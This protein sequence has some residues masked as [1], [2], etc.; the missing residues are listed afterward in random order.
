MTRNSNRRAAF[1]LVEMLVAAT[2]IIFMMYVLASAFEK[3]LESFRVLKAQGDMNEKLRAAASALRL[4]LATPHFDGFTSPNVQGPFLSNQRLNDQTWQPPAKGYFR[5]SLP[6]INPGRQNAAQQPNVVAPAAG[7]IEGTDP[8]NTN[9][10]Y[11]RLAYQPGTSPLICTCKDLYLQFTVNL[12][13]GHPMVRD[14]RGR[15]DQFN[16]TDTFDASGDQSH[17]GLGTSGDGVLNPYS[18]PEYNR[19]DRSLHP[20]YVTNS[21]GTPQPAGTPYSTLY[22]SQ[23]AEVCY[24]L[25]P[26]TTRTTDAPLPL[27]DLY[28]RQKMLVEPAPPNTYPVKVPLDSN[29]K[30]I[31]TYGDLSYWSAQVPSGNN[32]ATVNVFNGAAHVTMPQRRWGMTT[33]QGNVFYPFGQPATNL[34]PQSIQPFRRAMDEYATPADPS[35][36]SDPRSGGDL[37]LTDVVNFEI[38]ALWEPVRVGAPNTDRFR[39]PVYDQ[40][41]NFVPPAYDQNGNW[42]G[43][44]LPDYFEPSPNKNPDYPFDWLPQGI[45]PGINAENS[46]PP[47]VPPP[48]VFDTWS[49]NTDTPV[50]GGQVYNYGPQYPT[51]TT[52]AGFPVGNQMMQQELGMWNVGHF[53]PITGLTPQ[54]GPQQNPYSPTQYTI[55]LRV[56]VR[57]LQIKLRIWD[58]KS[59]QTRQITIIQDV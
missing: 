40:N 19:G 3:G 53:T 11:Y 32:T 52:Q 30:S 9:S 44:T 35:G 12:T 41:G 37:L 15:R 13:D 56:R 7:A 6:G 43:G 18:Q 21:Q 24:F 22:T 8:D 50:P 45:N 36:L 33:P 55:P 5:I 20:S 48:V 28:R 1:T 26:N 29:G 46:S 42:T 34:N 58:Q 2:L 27:Y 59:Q 23:W 39:T 38:K 49:C 10:L 51:G 54:T 16:M 17:L 57:A 25:V 47:G 4:D 31:G 14:A